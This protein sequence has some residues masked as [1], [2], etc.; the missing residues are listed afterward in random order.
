[1][2]RFMKKKKKRSVAQKRS[3]GGNSGLVV[4]IF[5]VLDPEAVEAYLDFFDG[6]EQKVI[7]LALVVINGIQ[8]LYH[9]PSLGRVVDLSIVRLELQTTSQFDNFDGERNGLL[10]S[11]CEYQGPDSIENT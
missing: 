10:T 11:F 4:E 6:D 8:A 1:M 9:Y 5:V 2:T 7:E 3:A